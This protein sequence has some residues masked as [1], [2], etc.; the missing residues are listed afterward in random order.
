MSGICSDFGIIQHHPFATDNNRIKMKMA[1][2]APKY[3]YKIG[4]PD[5]KMLYAYCIIS[6]MGRS[7][8]IEITPFFY[9]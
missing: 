1:K 2:D 7:K 9:Y 6:G 5:A 3:K 4:E 8:L